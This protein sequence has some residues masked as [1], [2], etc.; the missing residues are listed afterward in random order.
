MICPKCGFEMEPREHGMVR[1]G[2]LV[3]VF[4]CPRCGFERRNYY[5]LKPIIL[6]QFI[7]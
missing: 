3:A 5:V 4:K 7:P 6:K 1:K 2:L